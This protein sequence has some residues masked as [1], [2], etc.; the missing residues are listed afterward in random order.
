MS[1]KFGT[2]P[3]ME[4]VNKFNFGLCAISINL[5]SYYT[6]FPLAGVIQMFHTLYENQTLIHIRNI[7]LFV[8]S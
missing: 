8:I 1:M 4:L 6:N 7:A 3:H 2:Q 5:R